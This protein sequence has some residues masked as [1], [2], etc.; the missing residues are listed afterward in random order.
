L[1]FSSGSTTEQKKRREERRKRKKEGKE[2]KKI[3]AQEG[4]RE[5]NK[6]GLCVVLEFSRGEFSA[7]AR[8]TPVFTKE[9]NEGKQAGL[10]RLV[11]AML[12]SN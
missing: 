12:L 7:R 11:V 10:L 4:Q 1:L 2:R 5:G 8:F 6:A 3:K 9:L